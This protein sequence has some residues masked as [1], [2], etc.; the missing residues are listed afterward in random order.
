MVVGLRELVSI[1]RRRAPMKVV[2]SSSDWFN[3][4]RSSSSGMIHTLFESWWISDEYF[5]QRRIAGN[6]WKAKTLVSSENCWIYFPVYPDSTVHTFFSPGLWHQSLTGSRRVVE[7]Y[8]LIKMSKSQ[9]FDRVSFSCFTFKFYNWSDTFT[10]HFSTYFKY[11]YLDT[12]IRTIK[13]WICTK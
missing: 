1:C 12:G 10:S 5:W 13:K 11:Q 3:Q 4:Y 7:C 9:D 6:G 8:C 2:V